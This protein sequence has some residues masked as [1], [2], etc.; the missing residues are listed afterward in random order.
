MAWWG[1][2]DIRKKRWYRGG[3]NTKKDAQAV[4]SA[5]LGRKRDV[6]TQALRLRLCV[7]KLENKDDGDGGS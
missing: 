5:I 6:M 1:L 4:L 2:W 3:W 7:K